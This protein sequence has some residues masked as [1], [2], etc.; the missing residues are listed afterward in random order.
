VADFL[1]VHCPD[2][3]VINV[4]VPF[5]YCFFLTLLPKRRKK[6][7][8]PQKK[9]RLNK[10]QKKPIS[11]YPNIQKIETK[12]QKWQC[13]QELQFQS[14]FFN[15]HQEV[16]DVTKGV[17]VVVVVVVVAVS[18]CTKDNSCKSLQVPSQKYPGGQKPF[19]FQD[20]RP[21]MKAGPENV[22]WPANVEQIESSFEV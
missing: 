7:P 10:K 17:V 11:K 21:K 15:F 2:S 4:S 3:L 19:Q 14:C 16:S 1:C 22:N 9:K 20:V 8:P 12:I 6:S 5:Q 13:R 18:S